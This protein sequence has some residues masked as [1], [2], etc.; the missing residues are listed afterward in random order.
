MSNHR[1]NSKNFAACAALSILLMCSG[2]YAELAVPGVI[3]TDDRRPMDVAGVPW[4]AVGKIYAPRFSNI[5]EC[6]GTLIDPKVVVTAAHCL[7][8]KHS[9]KPVQPSAIHF[10][11]GYRRENYAGHAVADCVNFSP[12]YNFH[13]KLSAKSVSV[14]Y[15][16]IVLKK[17]LAMPIVPIYNKSEI[18]KSDVLVHAGYGRDRRYLLSV[19][20]GCHAKFYRDN[21]YFTDCDTAEGQSGGPVFVRTGGKYAI[22]AVM[23]SSAMLNS[24]NGLRPFNLATSILRDGHHLDEI[25]NCK[26][27]P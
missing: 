27:R 22:A 4:D 1:A 16:F 20:A 25:K 10:L 11:A 8:D 17:P 19:H 7:F 23:S 6:T 9:A 5:V 2:V 13:K 3:G 12:E 24:P 14:D 15:A 18:G 21:T 26:P